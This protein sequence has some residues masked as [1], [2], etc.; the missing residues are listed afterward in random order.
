MGRRAV[1]LDRDGV[2]CPDRGLV[3][4]ADEIELYPSAPASI[5]RL[6]EAGFSVVVVTNQPVVARG[7]A[8]EADVQAMNCR[9]QE[10]LRKSGGSRIDGFYYCPHHPNATLP[11]YRTACQCRK[12][13]SGLLLQ[14]AAEMALDLA[15][16][17]MV[18]DRPSDIA[19]GRRAGCATVLV[20]TGQHT[21][22]PI[23]SPDD[24]TADAKPDHVRPD[25]A[26]AVELILRGPA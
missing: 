15:A 3:T 19:A 13:R 10:L 17:Y 14:A 5:R 1:F 23:E 2:L 25:L 9:V 20:E 22:P 4:A 8:T 11:Q 26:A 16:S 6:N 18:G 21:A 24:M 12:P 7:L